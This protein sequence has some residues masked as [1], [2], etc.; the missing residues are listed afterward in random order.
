MAPSERRRLFYKILLVGLSAD[1]ILAIVL[2]VAN[3]CKKVSNKGI[4]RMVKTLWDECSVPIGTVASGVVA[5]AP[6]RPDKP[7]VTVGLF[8][9]YEM[10]LRTRYLYC[11]PVEE[12]V[13]ALGHFH[14]SVTFVGIVYCFRKIV[15]DAYYLPDFSANYRDRY[16]KY[17]K[18]MCLTLPVLGLCLTSAVALLVGVKKRRPGYVLT[19][20]IL[21]VLATLGL[22]VYWLVQ[23]YY[24]YCQCSYPYYI[25]YEG[26]IEVL[27]ALFAYALFLPT[28]Y[29]QYC[30]IRLEKDGNDMIYNT[31][32]ESN[33]IKE[34][35]VV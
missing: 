17:V 31:S 6:F 4:A 2:H 9:S 27:L 20:F 15:H 3:T 21:G 33:K 26:G 18:G 24:S 14:A 22:A 10:K 32:Q 7:Y 23:V 16:L 34:K 35:D 30:N 25:F 5:G 29:F 19:Y 12:A 8:K 1:D 11:I 13:T 28:V